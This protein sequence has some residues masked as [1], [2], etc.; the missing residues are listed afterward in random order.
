MT[1]WN[2]VLGM[3]TAQLKFASFI[4]M[5]L[6]LDQKL[7]DHISNCLAQAAEAGRQADATA[8]PDAK[9]DFLTLERTWNEL[10]H[11][12]QFAASLERFLLDQR[13]PAE[14]ESPLAVGAER[15][16]SRTFN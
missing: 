1:Y 4:L 10:A 5:E 2:A 13:N 12:F 15:R 9:D 7:R 14:R 6:A 16:F 11:G 8:D 3:L